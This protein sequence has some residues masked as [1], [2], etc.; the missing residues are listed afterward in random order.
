VD[1]RSNGADKRWIGAQFPFVTCNLNFSNDVNL[2]YL[3]TNQILRDTAF[4]T[5]AAITANTQKRGIAPSVIIERNGE[6]IGIVGA[7]TQVLAAISSPGAT[8]VLGGP[9]DNMPLLASIIQPVV[10]SLVALGINKIVLLS[11]L[12]Q[13]ANE[14]ALA[15]LLRNVDIIIPAINKI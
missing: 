10:D 9:T 15:P 3:F 1:I 13:I 8:S 4:R 11:H 2:S 14:K 5:P 6:R 7:T 12:Q